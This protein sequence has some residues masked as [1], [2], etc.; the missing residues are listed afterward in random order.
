MNKLTKITLGLIASLMV[1]T[2]AALAGDLSIT[3]SAKA[4]Y[5]IRGS[6]S[7]SA[8]VGAPQGI[9]IANEFTLSASGELDNGMALTYAQ[10]IDGATV[11]DDAAMTLNTPYGLFKACVHECG[12]SANLAFDNSVYGAGSDYGLTGTSAS[13]TAAGDDA[14]TFTWGTN[15]SS[16]N[17]VQFHTPAD[18]LPFGI[19]VKVGYA[20]EMDGTMNS[21]NAAATSSENGNGVTQYR[22]DAAPIDGLTLAASYL[23]VDDAK[24]DSTATTQGAE[25][26]GFAVTYAV[27]PATIGYGKFYVAPTLGAASQGTA[28][29]TDYENSSWSLGVA[30]NDNL[31]FS[32]NLE[33]SDEHNKTESQTNTTT[34]TTTEFE[35]RTIQAAYTMGG[36]TLSVANK[37]LENMDYT[38]DK[39]AAETIFSVSMAF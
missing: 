10:D 18:L 25:H 29:V 39:D 16:Y 30:A 3:G 9:G 19:V 13:T 23:E 36:M 4:T 12:L 5:S 38:A 20:P 14:T 27:G 8:Q 34:K 22:V 37:K 33:S 32:Y 35:I 1:S 24:A 31:S 2:T 6:E 17:N 21:S 26:G 7:A 11:Q 28:R 15:I